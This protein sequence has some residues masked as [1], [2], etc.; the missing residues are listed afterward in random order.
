MPA[1]LNLLPRKHFEIT[2]EDGKVIKGQFGTWALKRLTDKRKVTLQDSGAI[3]NTLPGL[4]DFILCAVEYTSRKN[5][6]GF[7]YTDLD[8]CDWVDQL[9]G[10]S[11]A[12]F[13]ELTKHLND[14]EPE[15]EE[16]KKTTTE[17]AVT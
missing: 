17:E 3:L 2:L 4:L 16:E 12:A 5:S 15:A 7:A 14:E 10:V 8:V 9:G 13:A 11:A 6:E 1:T